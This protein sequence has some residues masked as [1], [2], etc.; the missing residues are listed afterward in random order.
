[1]D[2]KYCFSDETQIVISNK[3]RLYKW[4]S[5]EEEYRLEYVDQ[6][7]RNARITVTFCGYVTYSVVGSDVL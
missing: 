6:H 1:M 5:Q 2:E 7:D 3:N 4:I